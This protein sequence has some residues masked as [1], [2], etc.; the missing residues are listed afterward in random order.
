MEGF[1]FNLLKGIVPDAL[2]VTSVV[3]IEKEKGFPTL[4]FL[5]ILR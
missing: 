4:S 1:P 5:S 2:Y 3:R